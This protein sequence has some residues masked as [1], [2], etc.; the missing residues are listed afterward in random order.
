MIKYSGKYFD[1]VTS[2]QHLVQ[3][4]IVEDVKITLYFEDQEL[5]I[6]F[7]EVN[8]IEHFG[9]Q[10]TYFKIGKDFPYRTIEIDS[11]EVLQR[12][13]KYSSVADKLHIDIAQGGIKN[14]ILITAI[15]FLFFGF[16]IVYGLP[17]L[18]EIIGG[19]IP[20]EVEKS[21]GE[22]YYKQFVASSKVDTFKTN[23]IN[24]LIANYSLSAKYKINLT[25]V[26]SEQ[27]NAFALPGG[28]IVI[29]T[30]ILEEMDKPEQLMGLVAHEVTHINHRHSMRALG[31][32]ISSYLLFSWVIGDAAGI[33]SVLVENYNQF[34]ALSYSRELEADADKTG[35]ELMIKNK[36]DP[37]GMIELMNI[38]K[39]EDKDGQQEFLQTHPLTENRISNLKKQLANQKEVPTPPPLAFFWQEFKK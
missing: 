24:K 13:K 33:T 21:I 7:E 30:G 32:S 14:V 28:Y 34:M 26:E 2:K 8:T 39:K 15:T 9:N 18:G 11:A 35:A 37:K 12:T 29:F 38:L 17:F 3:V 4:A 31:R 22:A 36:I 25:V 23:S 1:G 19:N 5:V 16:L 10:T 6:P 27:K 20:I